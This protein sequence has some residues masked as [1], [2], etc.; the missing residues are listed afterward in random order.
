LTELEQFELLGQLQDLD[1]ALG[2]QRLVLAAEGAEVVVVGMGVGGEQ[3]H[4]DA[5]KAALLDATAAESAGG[6]A[7]PMSRAR[8]MRGGYWG[9]PVPRQLTLTWRRSRASTASRMK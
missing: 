7:V 4:R 1:E 5:I 3:T 6:V 2:Q 8:S 9:L